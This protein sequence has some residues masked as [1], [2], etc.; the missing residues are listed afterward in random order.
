MI[1]VVA[2]N[3]N[4]LGVRT[5]SR[6]ELSYLQTAADL[7]QMI[8]GGHFPVPGQRSDHADSPRVGD[9]FVRVDAAGPGRLRQ[10]QRAVGLPPARPA[11]AT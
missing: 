3:T 4:L 7:T 8:A 9:G 2:R 6:L 5:P 10:P 1:A 11:R